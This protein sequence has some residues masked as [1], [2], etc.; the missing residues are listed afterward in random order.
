[1]LIHYW[2]VVTKRILIF[3]VLTIIYIA[4]LDSFTA[5]DANGAIV[6]IFIFSFIALGVTSVARGVDKEE[7]SFPWLKKIHAWFLPL[8]LIVLCATLIGFKAPKL[9]PIWPDPVPYLLGTT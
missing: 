1:Y 3:V 8:L 4:F 9:D 6:R 7:L 5:Y 2:F